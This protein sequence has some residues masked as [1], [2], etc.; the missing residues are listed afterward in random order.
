VVTI[1]VMGLGRLER[2]PAVAPGTAPAPAATRPV[3]FGGRTHDTAIVERSAL[4]AGGSI[5]G[6]AIVEEPTA[7]T[8]VPP[9][10]RVSIAAGGHMLLTR[11]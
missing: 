1:R 10:W 8:I 11:G 2:P 5:A 3:I 7:T 6:P 4:A 9:G